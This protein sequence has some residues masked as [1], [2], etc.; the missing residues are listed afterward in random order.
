MTKLRWLKTIIAAA[1]TEEVSLP[2]ERGA[3][4]DDLIIRRKAASA[5]VKAK[6]AA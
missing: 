2:W 1:E 5:P 6:A 4:R 3:R